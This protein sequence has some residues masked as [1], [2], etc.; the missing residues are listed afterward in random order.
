MK[1]TI[2]AMKQI[3]DKLI[4]GDLLC[5]VIAVSMLDEAIKQAEAQH[6]PNERESYGGSHANFAST[7][8]LGNSEREEARSVEPILYADL[9]AINEL[10]QGSSGW[11]AAWS[12]PVGGFVTPLFTHP[13]PVSTGER[14]ALIY[15]HKR[16][17]EWPT[18]DQAIKDYSRRTVDMLA[19]DDL[20]QHP[21]GWMMQGSNQV[22]KGEYAE[23][24]AIADAK[25]IGGTCYAYPIY[26]KP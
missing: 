25:R 16:C 21:H 5:E 6:P 20:E 1:S 14:A 9:N 8:R 3:R 12:K 24:N 26:L 19:S 11:V 23:E 17:A 15:Y 4:K 18:N 13:V 22:F 7:I 10:K 2:E